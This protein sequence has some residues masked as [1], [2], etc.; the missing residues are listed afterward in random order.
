MHIHIFVLILAAILCNTPLRAADGGNLSGTYSMA[1]AK[2]AITLIL[3]A[4]ADGTLTGSLNGGAL[5]ATLKGFPAETGAI[6]GTLTGADGKFLSYFQVAR[7]G[8][9]VQFDL[10]QAN[11]DGDPDFTKKSRLTFP[12]GGAKIEAPKS[13]TPKP[14]PASANFAGTF[15]D[16]TLTLESKAE[17]AGYSGAIKLAGQN[18]KFTAVAKEGT[19]RGD[20][21]SPDGKFPFEASLEGRVLKFVT[22]G[23]TYTLTKQGNPLA[24]PTNT[25]PNPLSKP[26]GAQPDTTPVVA[27]PGKSNDG[28]TAWKIYKHATGL[29]VRY[30]PDWKVIVQSGIGV[31]TP[32]NP[33][34]NANGPMEIYLLMAEAANGVTSIDD[35][36]VTPYIEG[37]MQ[38]LAPFLQRVGETQKVSDGATPGLLFSWDGTNPLGL[39]V[40]ANV[41]ATVLKGF[42]VALL[43][44]GD[45]DKIAARQTVLNDVFSSLAA[46]AGERDAQLVGQWKF[47]S[48]ISSAGGKSGTETTRRFRFLADGTCL[49]QSTGESSRSVESGSL[50][51]QS[52]NGDTGQWTAANGQ[53]FVL[54]ADGS[55]GTWQYEL[56]TTENG[57]RLFLKSDN[58]ADE[59]VP[60]D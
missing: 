42:S 56:R 48:Y 47:W 24:K 8:D 13:E 38:Q 29:S 39:K 54:W 25:A 10:V 18:F 2:G 12:A 35:P 28:K 27:L 53:L 3:Q 41:M 40:R 50:T 37:Q 33:A 58:K 15:K 6:L 30:P 14:A 21:E 17:G 7:E 46:G 20:F 32:P 36:R 55:A 16:D 9:K 31:L 26:V 45:K 52:S 43:A 22:E 1:G 4:G 11:A 59:W 23:T 57:K 44:M 19:L 49:W 5:Q 34:Q 51:S 60:E